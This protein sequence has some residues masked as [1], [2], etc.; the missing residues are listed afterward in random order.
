MKD[1][2][3]LDAQR[4]RSGGHVFNDVTALYGF[5]ESEYVEGIR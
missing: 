4:G 3:K 2:R 1:A 5:L